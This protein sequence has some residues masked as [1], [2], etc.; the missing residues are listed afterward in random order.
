MVHAAPLPKNEA[1]RLAALRHLCLLGTPRDPAFDQ[2]T[3]I[4]SLVFDS[5][6]ALISLVDE[7]RQWFKSKIGFETKETPRSQ[8]FC[9]YALHSSDP[10]IV[11]DTLL[12]ERF[13][14]NPL[15]IG[16]PHLRFYAGA[17]LI[18]SD[19]ICLGTFCI[20]GPQPRH[21]FTEQQTNQLVQFA[22]LAMMRIETLRNIGYVDPLTQLPNRTRFL[23]DIKLWTR[24]LP[25]NG[26]QLFAVA[27]DI[28]NA[29][30]FRQML[31]TFG[32]DYAD[33]FL[34]A[35]TRRIVSAISPAPVYRVDPTVYACVLEAENGNELLA[36]LRVMQVQ[37]CEIIEHQNIPH[38]AQVVMGAV[39]ITLEDSTADITRALRSALSHA[40][41]NRLA[42]MLY[43]PKLDL[44]QHRAFRILAFL[45]IYFIFSN[46]ATKT[47]STIA[48]TIDHTVSS[49]QVSSREALINSRF[50][51]VF[52]AAL[53]F[54]KRG[55]P[56]RE[57]VNVSLEWIDA[58]LSRKDK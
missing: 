52:P 2:M 1:E 23:E 9:A 42:T 54:I 35:A 45:K 58:S 25:N 16:A 43:Q 32:S 49:E 47:L 37:F 39:E 40:R 34:L 50:P 41:T 12:D 53:S 3:K 11:L 33:W 38:A 4:A 18:T 36:Q 55:F 46:I 28:C 57:L 30:Y 22:R 29:S 44:A 56:E 5:P 13:S 6:I 48:F 15:V 27:I 14:S 21:E 26:Q 10:L 19:G 24:D 51:G 20:L 17:P 31:A 7:G 8:A